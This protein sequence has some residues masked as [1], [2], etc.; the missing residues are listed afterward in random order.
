VD[1]DRGGSELMHMSGFCQGNRRLGDRVHP[2]MARTIHAQFEIIYDTQAPGQVSGHR[3][4]SA[5]LGTVLIRR[6]LRQS[7]GGR[8]GDADRAV[9]AQVYLLVV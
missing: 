4:S 5:S 2:T 7:S 8:L 1:V 3:L 6:N 9:D